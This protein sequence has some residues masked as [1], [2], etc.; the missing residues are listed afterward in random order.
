MRI[1][2]V[3]VGGAA[4]SA[5]RWALGGALTFPWGTIVAN[6]LGAFALGYVA[7]W[8]TERARPTR[9]LRPLVAIGFL[10]TFTTFSALAVD[11]IL[12]LQD[13]GEAAALVYW[14]TTLAGGL[15]AGL[16]GVNLARKGVAA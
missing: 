14:T 16:A 15:V 1:G 7:V 9:I 3:F 13:G 10:G 4:G 11:G 6:L 12:L 8:L 2:A 5:L